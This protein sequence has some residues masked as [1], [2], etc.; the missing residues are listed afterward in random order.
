M[1]QPGF[2]WS[3]NA[4]GNF[5]PAGHGGDDIG[6]AAGHMAEQHVGVAIG[7]LGVGGNDDI[8]AMVERPLAERCHGR[9]VDDKDRA[10]FVNSIGNGGDIADIQPRIGRG[11]DKRQPIAIEAAIEEGRG[12]PDVV[13]DAE[14]LEEAIGQS[15]RRVIAVGRQQDT[16]ASFEHGKERRRDCRH[17]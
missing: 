6:I 13:G 4:A 11:F 15:P 10:G 5:A 17:S 3:G 9:V 1:H 12:R 8:G 16:V 14:R 7:C 2:E